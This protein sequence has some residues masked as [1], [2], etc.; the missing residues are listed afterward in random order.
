LS[1]TELEGNR[2]V[3]LVEEISKQCTFQEAV[4]LLLSTFSLVYRETHEQ[5]A[6]QMDLKKC[7]I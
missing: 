4:W 3:T 6:E 7:A 2:L 5:K 1:E